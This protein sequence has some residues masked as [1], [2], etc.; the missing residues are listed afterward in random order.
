MGKKGKK[1]KI[2]RFYLRFLL[3][4]LLGVGLNEFLCKFIGDLFL[5]Y[6]LHQ[7]I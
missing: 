3:I 5:G 7:N 6:F 2:E 1:R 4:N